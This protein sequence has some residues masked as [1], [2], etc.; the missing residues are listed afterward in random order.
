MTQPKLVWAMKPMTN[1]HASIYYR[2]EVPLRAL[3]ESKR[4]IS[5]L[6]GME[7]TDASAK[8]MLGAD[9]DLFYSP[10][11]DGMVD[12]ITQITFMRPLKKG[13]GS[14]FIPPSVIYDCD[15]NHD[16]CHPFN[17][18]FLTSGVRDYGTGEF[19]EVGDCVQYEDPAGKTQI[20]WE[21]KVTK[22]KGV[23]FDVARNLHLMKTRHRIMRLA[24]GVTTT[25]P[26]LAEYIREVV[27][28]TNTYVFPN[29][30]IPQDYESFPLVPRTDNLVRILWQGGS[31]HYIDWYPL[32]KAMHEVVTKYP[33]TKIVIYGEKFDWIAD[34]IPEKQ[35]EYIPWTDYL[36]YKLRR[37]L[38]QVDI[39]L[40][41]LTNNTFNN[42]KSAI[43]W[44]EGSVWDK[45]EAT[46]AANVS[47]YKDEMVDNETGLLY[48]TPEE[49]VQK[50]GLLIEDAQ[51]RAR[52][53]AAAKK[54]VMQN[55]TP[56]ATIP[57]L[58]DFYLDCRA[59][60]Q[61]EILMK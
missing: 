23:V 35:L 25:V 33:Q 46:L 21:D 49:F 40:C 55:R 1:A 27:G 37:G 42:C 41:P 17:T 7:D 16:Y 29:T 2:L 47:P 61:R 26:T 52:L 51:L 20:L 30:I 22:S 34:I 38:L 39:N 45:P 11:G 4:T 13:D 24:D 59:R 12:Q 36:A 50:L 57:G 32:R 60:K 6:D 54:W 58:F 53:G 8:M 15:D 28:Q 18:P 9:F 48:N 31:S 19:L 3:Q 10:T 43:K 44:Y 5:F 14:Y 56:E